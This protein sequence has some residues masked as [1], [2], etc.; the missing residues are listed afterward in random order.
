MSDLVAGDL[1]M[2]GTPRGC[3]LQ[4]PRR[5]FKHVLAKLLPEERKWAAFLT[6]QAQSD[7]YLLP[8]DVMTARIRSADGAIDL[9]LQQNR[10]V[11]G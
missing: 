1:V 8:G 7:R 5:G 6:S 10:I 2:T 11:Q 4:I 3:A 9:G